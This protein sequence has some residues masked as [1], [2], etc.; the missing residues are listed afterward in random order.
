MKELPDVYD[1]RLDLTSKLESAETELIRKS[2]QLRLKPSD[3]SAS[4]TH[5]DVEASPS[6]SPSKEVPTLPEDERPTHKLG[7]LGLF[8]E[9]VDSINWSRQEIAECNRILEEGKKRIEAYEEVDFGGVEAENEEPDLGE[10]DEGG[11]ITEEGAPTSSGAI[12]NPKVVGKQAKHAFES[13][14]KTAVKGVVEGSRAIRERITGHVVGSEE[15]YPRLGS[16][17]IMFRKQFA[18]HIAAQVVAHHTPYRMG[19]SPATFF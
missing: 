2:V 12:F 15:D 1:R 14:G 7:F 5:Q 13:A 11:T 4:K 17:F 9:K 19:E 18:A 10:T 3:A 8:G 6:E 16:A